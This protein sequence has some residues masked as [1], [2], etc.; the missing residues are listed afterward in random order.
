MN[1][2]DSIYQDPEVYWKNLIKPSL[3][4]K[5]NNDFFLGKDPAGFFIWNEKKI[6]RLQAKNVQSAI[7]E[8]E[9]ELPAISKK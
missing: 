7:K 9:Y 3:T 5:L 8:G 2:T 4:M 1:L 6:I